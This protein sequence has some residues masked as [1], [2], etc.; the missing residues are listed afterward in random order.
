MEKYQPTPEEVAK[1]EGMMNKEQRVASDAREWHARQLKSIGKTGYLSLEDEEGLK[2]RMVGEIDGHRIE[3][4]VGSSIAY[5]DTQFKMIEPENF[6]GTVDG[7]ELSVEDARR[8]YER[9]RRYSEIGWHREERAKEANEAVERDTE[10]LRQDKLKRG[11]LRET[12]E[13][14]LA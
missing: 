3:I 4:T 10:A 5:N 1:A 9:Y 6:A 12:L 7:Q 2:H 11:N 8:L 14:L 13:E